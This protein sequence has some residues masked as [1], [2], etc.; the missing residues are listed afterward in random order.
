MLSSYYIGAS[1]ASS[2]RPG[3]RFS[4]DLFKTAFYN[5]LN[6]RPVHFRNGKC[7]EKT[8]KNMKRLLALLMA[9]VM[10][11]GLAGCGGDKPQ[12]TEQTGTPAATEAS[13]EAPA[14][15]TTAAPTPAETEPDYT[16]EFPP[17]AD[18]CNQLVLY[19]HSDKKVDIQTSDVWIWW[20]E[21]AGRGYTFLPCEYGFKC[22]VN[23]PEDITEVGITGS[24]G[25]EGQQTG[26]RIELSFEVDACEGG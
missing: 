4:V 22:V 25:G 21:V 11:F 20:G 3:V 8:M 17:I 7:E 23:V 15:V 16:E 18:G 19:W 10:V 14:P 6:E 9:S 26:V 1:A 13:T 24:L 2:F 5:V 12:S